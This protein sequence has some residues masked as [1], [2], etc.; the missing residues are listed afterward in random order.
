MIISIS[1]RTDIPAYYADWFFKRIEEQYVL[2][3]NPV[4]IHQ[5]SRVS[6]SPGAVDCIVF[7]TKNPQPMLSALD[8]LK[9]YRYYFQFTLT[10]Y[11]GD[12]EA[13]L[14]PKP[15]LIDT[16]KVLADTIGK[17]KVIWRYDPILINPAYTIDRHVRQFERLACSLA[18]H[19][20]K[21][22]ISFLDFYPKIAA[23][24]R[25]LGVIPVSDGQK[26]HIAKAL[27]EIA[28]SYGLAVDACAETL[29]LPGPGIGHARCV[30]DRLISRITGSPIRAWKDR[31][32]RPACGCAESVD[33]GA[34]NTCAHGCRYCYAN[35]SAAAVADSRR[36]YDAASPLLCSRLTEADTVYQRTTRSLRDDQDGQLKMPFDLL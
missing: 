9:N 13:S 16:F 14:P 30:D 24:V 18:G 8:R 25:T 10:A 22:V 35:H 28:F 3:R 11:S 2:M 26:R 32:Q 36:T 15:V 31:N 20:E 33:I 21:C 4:N 12:V 19:T 29:D 17:E 1:R 34:Y 5:V 6:L 23:A 7:W 27:S